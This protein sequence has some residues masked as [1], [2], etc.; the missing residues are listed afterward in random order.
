MKLEDQS[1]GTGMKSEVSAKLGHIAHFELPSL[2]L[3]EKAPIGL[4]WHD[5]S[6]VTDCCPLGF[7]LIVLFMICQTVC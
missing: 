7:F 5:G 2:D 4:S 1:L 6:Q 3:L